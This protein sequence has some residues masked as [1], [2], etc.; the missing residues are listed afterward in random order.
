[1]IKHFAQSLSKK[2]SGNQRSSRFSYLYITDVLIF[3][4]CDDINKR[5]NA[6]VLNY[7]I[8]QSRFH[9]MISD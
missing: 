5:T 3:I 8:I 6:Y 7:D 4:L 2:H 9:C 1:M